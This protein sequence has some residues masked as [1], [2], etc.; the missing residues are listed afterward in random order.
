MKKM[1]CLEYRIYLEP[2]SQHFIFFVTH[3]WA[4]KPTV[5]HHTWSQSYANKKSFSLLGPLVNY[6]ENE[7]LFDDPR[8]IYINNTSFSL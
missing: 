6:K 8:D 3:E 2:S 1:K 7:V 5:L 4:Q